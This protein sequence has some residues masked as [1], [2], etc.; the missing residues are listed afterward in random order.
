LR[1]RLLKIRRFIL[2]RDEADWVEVQN[3]ICAMNPA[4]RP[5]TVEEFRT[6]EKSPDFDSE[7]RFIAE[8]DGNPGE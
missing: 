1:E 4:R 8:L 6:E 5:L 7:G 3:A 2:G